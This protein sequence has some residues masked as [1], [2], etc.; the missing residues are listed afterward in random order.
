MTLCKKVVQ[1]SSLAL[2]LSSTLVVYPDFYRILTDEQKEVRMEVCQNMVEMTRIDP[3][4]SQ[5]IITQDETWVYQYDPE[6][7]LQSSQEGN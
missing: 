2:M 6:T 5:K 7:K 4:W 3:E 1:R